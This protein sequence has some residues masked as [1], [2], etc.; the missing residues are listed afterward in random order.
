M[1]NGFAHLVLGNGIRD[2]D[3]GFILMKRSVLTNVL[4]DPNGFGEYF[5]EFIYRSCRY[6]L[7]VCEVP[8]VL[9]E[10]SAGTSKSLSGI[11]HFLG[12]GMQYG[13]RIL[14]LRIRG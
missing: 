12:L 6:G 11:L 5:I 10:R 13:M 1:L 8:Y 7:R 14:T 3:S 9:T 4:P 2:Y